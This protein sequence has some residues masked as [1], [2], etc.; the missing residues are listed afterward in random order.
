ME[1]GKIIIE[2]IKVAPVIATAAE[3]M[4]ERILVEL[5]LR[6]N[7]AR[8]KSLWIRVSAVAASVALL[9]GITNYFSYRQ[10]YKHLNS[11]IVQQTNPLGMQSSITLSDGTKVFLNA[12]TTLSYPTAFVS[13]NRRVEVTG[14]AFFDVAHDTSRP[15]IVKTGNL[16][17]RVLGTKFNVKSY[18]EENNIEVTLEEGK[19][20]VGMEGQR[21]CHQV[22]PGQQLSYD[23][24][25]Q[26]FRSR[27]V[28][29]NHYI[30]W[31]EGKF[32]FE[33]MTFENIIRQ[34]E[35]R[36]DVDIQIVSDDLKKTVFTGDFVRG[37]NLEQIL[38]V[39]TADK[40][41]RYK[42]DGDQVYIE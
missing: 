27:Q 28:N 40:R 21:T 11:Q 26:M 6:I 18:Q 24:T 8:R 39:M 30:I 36:F 22:K 33:S 19:V 10:G 14:E 35:R 3:E 5:N 41:I 29:L 2:A 32:Y 38:R 15:F 7:K 31:K 1:K 16:N 20:E 9:L 34:L 42:I 25:M 17:V 4:R 13:K 12:G 23:K 37:E